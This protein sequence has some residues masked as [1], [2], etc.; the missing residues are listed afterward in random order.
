[1]NSHVQNFTMCRAFVVKCRHFIRRP[2]L[3]TYS[4]LYIT[5]ISGFQ[6]FYFILTG[7]QIPPTSPTP[8]SSIRWV[9]T[10]A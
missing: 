8:T 3:P 7:R 1:M 5:Q 2:Q 6:K 9:I 10:K 4:E